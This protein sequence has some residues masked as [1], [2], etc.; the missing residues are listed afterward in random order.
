MAYNF[1]QGAAGAGTGAATGFMYGGPVGAAIG[2][3]GGAA[4]GFLGNPADKAM[5]SL[6]QIPD[7]IKP[8]YQKYINGGGWAQDQLQ[9]HYGED[10]N[11]PNAI[12]K[13]LGS[14]YQ[15]SPGYQFRLKQGEGAINNANAA[16]GMLG[17]PQHEQQAGEL[18]G[19]LANADYEQYLNHALGLYGQGEAGAE[20]LANRGYGA[21]TDLASSLGNA[22][23]S[24]AQ[25][26]YSGQANQNN[27]NGNLL[28]GLMSAIAMKG[29][30]QSPQ[31]AGMPAYAQNALYR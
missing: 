20:N 25:T 8:Y 27:M 2:G 30:G 21:S 26:G 6:D 13:R 9:N 14:G 24:K 7:T 12:I 4:T 28:T 17:S 11:D 15:E 22:L 1:G 23:T 3:L 18:A 31:S 10:M 29:S 5:K 19:N 16:G